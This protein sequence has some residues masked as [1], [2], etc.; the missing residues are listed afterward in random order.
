[1]PR[2]PTPLRDGLGQPAV[3][4]D[5][6]RL[7]VALELPGEVRSALSGWARAHTAGLGRLRLIE[8]ES[9]HVTL[10][11]LGLRPAAEVTE[12]GDACRHAASGHPAATL[13]V[14]DALWLPRRRP[15]LLGVALGDDE[16]GGLAATQAALSGA[17]TEGGFY[18][19][20]TRPFLAHVT[21]ARVARDARIRSPDLP[22]PEATRFSAARV[23]LFESQLGRGPARYE[24]LATVTLSG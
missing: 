15:R 4:D 3:S 19:P 23:T 20:E 11:F 21:V 13:T 17:L 7:F 24:A 6:V 18:E 1:M 22:A 16:H 5:R 8:P 14:G 2:G 9:L 12:I 10:C